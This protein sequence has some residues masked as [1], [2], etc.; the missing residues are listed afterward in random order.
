MNIYTGT[1]DGGKTSLFSGERIE[2]GNA[3]I[4]SYGDIDELNAVVGWVVA[5]LPRDGT[6]HSLRS[7]LVCI[8]SDLFQ[9]GALLATTPGS[10][11]AESLSPITDE[12]IRRLEKKIDAMNEHLAPL[13]SFIIPGGHPAA[14]AAHVVRAVCR[15]AERRVVK[16]ASCQADA[17]DCYAGMLVY[18]NRL[19]DYFFV[20]ARYC[21]HLTGVKEETWPGGSSEN[22]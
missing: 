7:E 21:N 22:G 15:R 11:A 10:P 8:Q 17:P 18:L 2:K 19:S 1:G 20:L 5:N 14:A 9:V 12:H 13:N 4:D 3:R 16:L 6:D